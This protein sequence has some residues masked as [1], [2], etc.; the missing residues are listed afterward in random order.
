MSR[1]HFPRHRRSTGGRATRTTAGRPSGRPTRRPS[2]RSTPERGATK[3][4][5]TREI[6]KISK[7]KTNLK[8][9]ATGPTRTRNAE[10]PSRRL[11]KKRKR[12][13]TKKTNQP[14]RNKTN[15]TAIMAPASA[16]P[17]ADGYWGPVTASVDWCERNYAVTFYAAEF[18]NASTGLFYLWAAA[19]GLR[20]AA[21]LNAE[22]R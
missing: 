4:G 5:I 6:E 9:L 20:Q 7:E 18:W 22:T 1:S 10:E 3:G 15:K 12:R 11:T 17:S 19:R 14:T 21:K 8:K 2:R 16:A 13:P